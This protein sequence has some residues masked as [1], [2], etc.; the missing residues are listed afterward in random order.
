MNPLLSE[1]AYYVS[2]IVFI[3][4]SNG[5]EVN[6]ILTAYFERLLKN[7][8]IKFELLSNSYQLPY[9]RTTHF[10][11]PV[12]TTHRTYDALNFIINFFAEEKHNYFVWDILLKR[13]S[14]QPVAVR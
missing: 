14:C 4:L 6:P 11:T 3:N 1:E 5:K 7:D 13:L 8:I 2:W 10:A 9:P 12:L